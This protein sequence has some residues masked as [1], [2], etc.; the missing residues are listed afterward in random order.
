[1]RGETEIAVTEQRRLFGTF[2]LFLQSIKC[3]VEEHS[4]RVR[5][6]TRAKGSIGTEVLVCASNFII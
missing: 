2:G 3:A 6:T 1:M 5:F 4:F